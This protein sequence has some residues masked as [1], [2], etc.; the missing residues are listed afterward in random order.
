VKKVIIVFVSIVIILSLGIYS[1]R[2]QYNINT[3][4]GEIVNL[5]HEIQET[6]VE[7]KVLQTELSNLTLISRIKPLSNKYLI[8]Y[9]QINKKD[10]I[11]IFD[12]PIN[13]L[14]E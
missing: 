12:I 13:P 7:I 1:A 4:Q 11:K 14:F 9:H 6:E 3:L 8:N 2:L 5:E 10:F